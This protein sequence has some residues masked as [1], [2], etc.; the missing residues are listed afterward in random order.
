MASSL[1]ERTEQQCTQSLSREHVLH[2]TDRADLLL[3]HG[4]QNKD[5]KGGRTT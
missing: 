4:W 5:E 2:G 1:S 3:F